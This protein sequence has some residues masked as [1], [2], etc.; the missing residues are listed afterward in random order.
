[1]ALGLDVKRIS[2][3]SDDGFASGDLL[4][5]SKS[6]P[7]KPLLVC[8][9]GGG[10]NSGYFEMRGSSPLP[11]ALE[12][13]MPVLLVNRP[14]HGGNP[15]L[16][17]EW[18]IVQ[19]VPVI[20][21]LIDKTRA[22]SVPEHEGIVIIG[23]SIGGAV[24]LML[25][26]GRGT[27]PLLGIAVSGIGD[28]PSKEIRKW[29]SEGPPDPFPPPQSATLFLGPEGTYGWQASIALR[30]SSE[31][32]QVAEVEEVVRRWPIDYWPSAA[33]LVDVPVHLRL[34]DH[35][36]IWETGQLVIDRMAASL[37]RSPHVD[38]AILPEGGHLYEIHKRGPELIASQLHFLARSA[39][40]S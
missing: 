39:T 19:M 40:R 20:R 22:A 11:A 35:D 24:A 27:W 31:P 2:I 18:P 30:R 38:A 29:Y 28:L 4:S 16:S 10:C 6:D 8:I 9:H 3:R 33:P 21:A 25:A 15:K 36:R 13:G 7:A 37:T 12:Q 1:M 32:W 17:G 26:A 14:G 23:H 34:A 5:P